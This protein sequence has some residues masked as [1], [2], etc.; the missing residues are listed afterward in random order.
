LKS[1]WLLFSAKVEDAKNKQ[2]EANGYARFC[3]QRDPACASALSCA[4]RKAAMSIFFI[5]I[6][7]SIAAWAPGDDSSR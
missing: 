7:A 2:P 6:M 1:P 4:S 3:F 5:F